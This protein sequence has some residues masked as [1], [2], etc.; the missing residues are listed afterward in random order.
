MQVYLFL[1]GVNKDRNNSNGDKEVNKEQLNER[2]KTISDEMAVVKAQYAK[3]EGHLGEAIHW[4]TELL[5]IGEVEVL[6]GGYDVGEMD[7]KSREEQGEP[8]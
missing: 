8:T 6:A 5:K 2:I 3:L 7:T 1:D 4:L